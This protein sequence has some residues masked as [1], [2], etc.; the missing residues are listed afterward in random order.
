VHTI[1]P[2]AAELVFAAVGLLS[3]SGSGYTPVRVMATLAALATTAVLLWGLRRRGD[4]PRRAVLWAWCPTV[5][6]EAVNNAHIDVVAALLTAGALLVLARA[7]TRTA[8]TWGA[9]LLGLAIATKVTPILVVPATLRRRT[10]TVLGA[11]IG[12]VV[13]VY[14][15]HLVA[16]GAGVLGY[17]PGYL[18]EEGYGNGDRFALLTL[19][20]P[21]AWA[22]LAAVTILALAAA[23]GL[24]TADPDRP[25]HTATVLTGTALLV[26]TPSYPWYAVLLVVL[27]ALGGRARWLL[28]A[29]AAYIGQ[30]Q[31]HLHLDVALAERISY[32][33]ALALII[34]ASVW[35]NRRPWVSVLPT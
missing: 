27:V 33:S 4:D 35:E 14:L 22:P 7:R 21:H 12:A 3:P 11:T 8:T 17:L 30:Y 5:A 19:V 18:N 16:V 10:L 32:G 28:V 34:G 2:P 15:P 13:L 20:V 6:V 23:W 26:T 9:A 31:Q 25:W 24:R 29:A 1:Y